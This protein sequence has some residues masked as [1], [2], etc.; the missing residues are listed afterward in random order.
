MSAS[1]PARTRGPENTGCRPRFGLG[2]LDPA[3]EDDDWD[4]DPGSLDQNWDP[5]EFDDEEPEPGHGDFWLERDD[6]F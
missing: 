3:D 4:L 2:R 5:G 1:R 6:E